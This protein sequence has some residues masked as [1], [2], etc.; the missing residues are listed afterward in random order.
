MARMTRMN[1]PMKC[2]S[3]SFLCWVA[4]LTAVLGLP[5]PAAAQTVLN[6]TAHIVEWDLPAQA[7]ASPG[8]MIVDSQG[9]DKNRLWFV[10][11]LGE[12]RV[13]R[14]DPSKSLM[15]GS[16][17][18]KAW[19]LSPFTPTVGGLRKLRGSWDRR[20]IFVRT[21]ESIQRIDT[22]SCDSTTCARLEYL[23]QL[24]SVNVSDMAVDD[25]NNLFTT[26]T[27]NP[28]DPTVS[29]V[30]M[31][32]FGSAVT[33]GSSGNAT[34]TRW[35]VGGGAGFCA[36]LGNTT[37]S[38]P[39]V[40][41]IAALPSNRNL[42]YYS[43]PY[44]TDGL[45]N[46]AE[47]NIATNNVRRWSLAALPPDTDGGIVKQPRQLAIDRWGVIW[48]ITGSGHLVSLDPCQNRMRKHAVPSALA[49]DP[50]GLAPDDDVVGYTDTARNMIGMLLPKGPTVCVSPTTLCAPKA[51][52]SKTVMGQL[53]D[54]SSG[55]VPPQ[56]KVIQAT[57]TTK[58]DGVFVEAQLDSAP[59][60]NPSAT[61]DSVS[62]LGITANKGKAQGTFFYAVG[63]N[64]T[65]TANRVGFVRMPMPEKVRHPRDDDDAEDGFDHDH[66]PSGWHNQG[67]R[68]DDDDDD[69]GIGGDND[70]PTAHENVNVNDDAPVQGGQHVDYPMVASP[71]SLALIFVATSVNDPLAQLKVD[72]YD[73]LGML[74]ATSAPTPGLG[75]AT[76]LL[77][78]AGNYTARV[79]NLGVTSNTHTPMSIVREPPEP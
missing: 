61:N 19:A 21:S 23:D 54:V 7:D 1:G 11:R 77:P 53:A 32:P 30:Q 42:V 26:G 14:M 67:Q 13:Y 33:N 56:G 55:S 75:I 70:S 59:P 20:Y 65:G 68:G 9:H 8:A 17:Q 5:A 71:T 44:G 37:T 3:L 51:C 28:G 58:T 24:G 79:S 41:G 34:V 48:V 49:S 57:I 73:S 72:I 10:T 60:S 50:F 18:W 63:A 36:D 16:A 46:I 74:M 15:A 25:Q 12:P 78:A 43:E 6:R 52:L 27:D 22:L 76:V 69:D 35:T 31:L 40:S 39:C 64:G 45:G 2:L 29:Y 66:H 4:G 62:P 47:L 38:F